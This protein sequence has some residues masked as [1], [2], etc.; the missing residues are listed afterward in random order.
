MQQSEIISLTEKL[1]PAYHSSDFDVIL[2]QLTEGEPPS[3]KLLVKMELK[4]I[5]ES[6]SKNVDL[7]GRVQGECREYQLNGLIHWF[8]DVA[9]NDY[10]KYVNKYGGYTE[11]VWEALY[12]TRNNYRVMKERGEEV[13]RQESTNNTEPFQVE[14]IQL[15]YDLK[16]KE[17]RLKISS[18][19]E[20]ELPNTQKLNAVTIDIS[21]SGARFKAPATFKYKLGE[22]ISVRYIE[23]ERESNVDGINMPIQYRILGIEEYYQNNAV[24]F[25]RCLKITENSVIENVI[26]ESFINDAQKNRHNNQDTIIRAR[27][28]AYEHTFLKHA[29]QLPIL[30]NKDEL[31]A[32]LLTNCNRHIWQYWHDERNQ[33]TL[34]GLFNPQR[35]EYLTKPGTKGTTATIYAFQHSHKEKQLFFSMIRTEGS[36]QERQLFWHLGAK[37]DSWRVFRLSVFELSGEEKQTLL[38]QSENLGKH[39]FPL[40]HIAILQEINTPD[41]AS[42]YLFV[43]KPQI[44][45]SEL[46]R[47]RQPRQQIGRPLSIFH[48]T[49]SQRKEPRYKLISPILL[50]TKNNTIISGNTVDIS[51]RGLSIQLESPTDL[52]VNDNIQIHF[53]E[54][55]I[56]SKHVSLEQVPYNVVRVNSDGKKIQ[57]VMEDSSSTVKIIVFLKKL[58]ESNVD[59]LLET[60]ELL[61]NESLLESFHDI[62]M[63]NIVCTPIYVERKGGSLATKAIG[64]TYPLTPHLML[65]A[66]LGHDETLSLEPIFRGHTS[67]LLANPMKHVDGAKPV[68]NEIYIS[69]KRFG[70]KIQ[71]IETRLRGDFNTTKS[72]IGFI[73]NAL[74]FGEI[75]IL[76]MTGLPIFNAMTSL[77]QK[78]LQELMTVSQF[79][80]KNIE[81]EINSL[82]G[83]AQLIDITEEV[84]IRLELND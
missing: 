57:L 44:Q 45:S 3:V 66:K 1:I 41:T 51:Q 63:N 6:C 74:L 61:P 24:V 69:V 31:K 42:D 81:K 78:D 26:E 84:L 32:V 28:R 80:A 34:G 79:H 82:T 37:R 46:N 49:Q 10:H 60:K 36:S 40:T 64:I 65:L 72:R 54:L 4:R 30:F 5:M 56:Y 55:K 76:Q 75:Y 39:L 73:R 48:D 35:M 18:Q 47:Y 52:K 15:G 13:P 58:F 23:I 25:L 59:K 2:S 11:G 9:L 50:T 16:R 17:N 70:T 38:D 67:T 83:Y 68:Y 8:D 7:R 53:I 20:I 14:T 71:S 27:T 12:N 22:T 21:P 29:C 62:L 33:Q 43:D 77:L 19:I